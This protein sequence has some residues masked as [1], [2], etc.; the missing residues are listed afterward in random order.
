VPICS[1][2]GQDNPEGFKFCPSCAAPLAPAAA[3]REQRKTVTVL[4]CDLTGSTALG[5]S[6][7][8]EALRSLLARYF[9]RMKAIVESHGGTVEKFIG[10]AVMAVFGVPKV[11]E[12]DALRAVRAA[13]EMRDALPEL[14]VQARIG[15]NT[16]EVVSGTAERL[17]TGDAVNV[18]ARLEQAAQPGEILMGENT[19]GLVRD[20]VEAASVEPL[21]LKGKVQSVSAF[22]LVTVIPEAARRH[23]APM[24]GRERELQVLRD[25]FARAESSCQL[26]TVFG[27]AGVGKSRLA[28][29]FLEGL[30]AL[31]VRGRCLSY[32]EG[33]TYWP[34]VEVLKQLDAL[35]SDPAAAAAL[36]SL[37]GETDQSTSAEQIAWGFRKLLEEQAQ[38]RPLV[39]VFDDIHWA[40]GT[41]L[42]LIEHISDLSRDAPILLLCM[43][44]PELLDKRQ[45]WG[46]G[47]LNA[48]TILL[49]SLSA[50]ETDSLLDA[51]GGVE[52]E[53]RTKI[54]A[55]AEGNPLFVE[56]MVALVREAAGAEITVP[57]TIHALLAARIDQLDT[58]DRRVLQCGAVEGRLFH[59]GALQALD[60]DE[61]QLPQRLASLVR[62]ELVRTDKSQVPGEEAYR[63]RHL[64]IR[65]VAYDALPKAARA[66]MHERYAVWLEER[67]FELLELD[68]ILGHHLEQA[69]SYREALGQPNAELA[70]RAGELLSSAGRRA[71][72]RADDRAAAHLLGRAL[73]LLRP[74]GFDVHRELEHAQAVRAYQQPQRAA[75]IATSVAERAAAACDPTAE[76]LAR[77]VAADYRSAYV[78]DPAVDELEE[79]ARKVLPVLEQA[80]DDAGLVHIW[81]A[82]GNVANF[83]GQYEAWAQA[84]EHALRHARRAGRHYAH[85]FGLE[86]ALVQG[87]RPA[88][89]ALVALDAALPEA[90]HPRSLLRRAGLIAMLGRF[91]EAWTNA[92]KASDRLRELAGEEGSGWL[93]DLATLEGDHGR[94]ANYLRLQCELFEQRGQRDLLSSYAPILGRSLCALGRH[95]E[96][97][98][99]ARLGREIGDEQDILTQVLWRQVEALVRAARG[100]H[101]KATALAEEA[102]AISERTDSPLLQA[103]A[104]CDL[105]EVLAAAG[106][107]GGA[108]AALEQAL[109]RYEWKKNIAM[110]AQVRPRLDS[111]SEKARQ[112]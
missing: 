110:V 102:T 106:R 35:P 98:P 79:L 14:G 87:P 29:E 77:A 25:A 96:A 85:L 95:Q 13:V 2:C 64:L 90:P 78:A 91:D 31:V 62:K 58:H 89:E 105:A 103:A 51:L 52:E 88:D 82:L 8:P 46:G 57:P 9:E 24:V 59:R 7:D 49:E 67:E 42:D 5:E 47:K 32:G 92:L 111:L 100:E 26:F 107:T 20:C 44:R 93:A 23:Q 19:F 27:T 69:A 86:A 40:E 97:E 48:T 60:P 22:R 1:N 43:A 15:V 55:A 37:L 12:D 73:E 50:E 38:E 33:I 66:E 104:L 75:T 99:L 41:F 71:L 6:T 30:E 45:G 21:E 34:V 56:E 80:Q 83:R 53:L 4:F 72:S 10:D 28:H 76:A 112:T 81:A 70:E 74:I 18:A 16:G 17:A 39:C 11:H 36:R 3:A 54:R 84:A 94:A 65:D 101:G 63:F 108:A 109:E 68:E 61:T